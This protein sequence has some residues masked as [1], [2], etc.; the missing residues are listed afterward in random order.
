MVLEGRLMEKEIVLA[1]QSLY[2]KAAFAKL[3]IPFT[4]DSADIDEYYPGRPRDPISLVLALAQLKAEAVAEKHQEKIVIGFDSVGYFENQ[5]LEKPKSKEE[6]I[7]RLKMLSGKSFKFV[8]GIYVINYP[9]YAVEYVLTTAWMRRLFKY[10]M[11]KYLKEDP[12][13]NT[14]ALGFDPLN[15]S[16]ASF[17][18]Q[19]QGSYTNIGYGIPLELFPRLLKGVGY[20]LE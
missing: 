18:N 8:T 19:I 11:V 4:A 12:N 6:L 15:Y 5:I 1:T 2:R 16:S 10:E 7:D 20:V 13:Y 14:Y 17:I 3:G 9:R